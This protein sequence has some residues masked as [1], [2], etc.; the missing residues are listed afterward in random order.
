MIKK[1]SIFGFLVVAIL[2]GYLIYGNSKKEATKILGSVN[3]SPSPQG[4]NQ[5][6]QINLNYNNQNLTVAW[7]NIDSPEKLTLIPNFDEKFSANVVKEKYGCKF[8]VNAGYYSKDAKPIG[9][10]IADGQTIS[11]WQKN[12]LLNGIFSIN[13]L[14]TPRITRTEP[15]DLLTIAIQTGPLIKEN[16]T[17]LQISAGNSNPDR[18]VLA[19]VTGENKTVFLIIYDKNSV[20]LGPQLSN[21]PGILK[22]FEEKSGLALADI[23]NL[24]GGTASA[25]ISPEVSLPEISP[26]GSFFCLKS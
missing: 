14:L 13:K 1:L 7:F 23:I 18:R 10:F 9:L 15:K 21:L 26:V 16:A 19:A 6:N 22:I 17:Y 11:R 20:F 3:S 25:F 5:T 12:Y 2:T 24:D 8:L 4:V